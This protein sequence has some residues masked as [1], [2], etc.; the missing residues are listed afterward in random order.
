MVEHRY[1]G[2]WTGIKIEVLRSY[3]SFF[4]IALKN[5]GFE[6]WYIDG[7]AGTGSRTVDPSDGDLFGASGA[8]QEIDGSARVALSI[9]PPFKRY[10]FIEKSPTRVSALKALA[11]G[12]SD[13]RIV[14]GDANAAITG[15]CRTTPWRGKDAP[16]KGIRAVM[17]LDPYGMSVDYATL[18]EIAQ[19]QSI[20]LWYLFP[21]SGLYR[22]AAHSKMDISPDKEASI[23]R[24]LGTQEWKT[25]LYGASEPDLFGNLCD[26]PRTADVN[27]IE[28]YVYERLA[29]V[30]PKV[31]KPLRLYNDRGVP[32]FSLFFAVSNPD[33]AAWRLATKAANHILNSGISSQ[34]RRR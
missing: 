5:Q 30:F 28:D 22:Q 31:P 27:T 16:G 3:L 11:E 20:D 34:T 32:I 33:P 15:I 19:T 21:L 2:P 23:T 8:S 1:G 24:I 29:K 4:A 6:L 18:Q 17:F 9:E 7:F 14:Q 26:G 12:R 10:I 25:R 13:V